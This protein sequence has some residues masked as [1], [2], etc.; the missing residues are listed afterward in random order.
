MTHFDWDT[1]YLICFGVGL[2]LSVVGFLSGVLH[3]HVGHLKLGGH[4][5]HGSHGAHAGHV[6]TSNSASAARSSN[7]ASP[8]NGFT[9]VAFLCWFGG[10]GYLL[11]R[12][13]AFTAS[14]VL[15]LSAISGF[16]G[17]A[18]VFW[19]LA[20]VLMAHERTLEPEDTEIVGVVGRVICAVPARGVGEIV[21]SQNGARRR[22][23]VRSDD[24][25]ELP[26]DTE[27][28]VI[29]YE[30]GVAL[31]RRWDEFQVGL[32]GAEQMRS[33]QEEVR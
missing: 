27:V 19:F 28:I 26:R 16:A 14:V 12:G 21:Y 2:V 4:G 30:R 24:G 20:R 31:V 7:S 32:L 22:V 8:F 6:G 25:L 29:R 13:H 18:V 10:T 15:L 11:H 23:A 33:G 5:A 3:L 17:A 1:F 9:V